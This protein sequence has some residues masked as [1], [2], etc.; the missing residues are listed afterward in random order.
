MKINRDPLSAKD[1]S[2]VLPVPYVQ[3]ITDVLSSHLG[4]HRARL[5]AGLSPPKRRKKGTPKR[6][7]REELEAFLEGKRTLVA[8]PRPRCLGGL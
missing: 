6:L 1:I 2:P 8:A 4:W 7:T 5:R 3:S